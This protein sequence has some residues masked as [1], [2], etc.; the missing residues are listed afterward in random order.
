MES[1]L[2]MT[3]IPGPPPGPP[4]TVEPAS[5]R[6]GTVDPVGRPSYARFGTVL[7]LQFVLLAWLVGTPGRPDFPRRLDLTSILI[8]LS[9][10]AVVTGRRRERLALAGLMLGAMAFS[11]SALSGLR[12]FNL[13]VGPALSVLCAAYTTWLLM[14]A[15]LRSPRITANVLGGAL[16]AYIMAGLAF[17]VAF[18]VIEARVPGAFQAAAG[19]P[20]SFSD[21][22]YFSFVTL[23]TIGFGDVTPAVPVARAVVV[24]EGL[25][26]V[27][28]TTIVMASLVAGYLRHREADA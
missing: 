4:N 26:G 16:A 23:L 19:V 27:V 20:A 15:V 18:G 6:S 22:V 5:S 28:F 21:L 2:K 7:L 12:P 13:D 11:G 3:S 9:G 14:R 24:F 17:A 25:F 10:I 1:A 8:P